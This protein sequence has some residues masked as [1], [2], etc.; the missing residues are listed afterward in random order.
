[1]MKNFNKTLNIIAILLNLLAGAM[2]APEAIGI[3][4]I[5]SWQQKTEILSQHILKRI[6]NAYAFLNWA[7]QRIEMD[8]FDPRKD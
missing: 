7:A 8:P 4:R 3:E 1:M 5:R 2:L 6:E